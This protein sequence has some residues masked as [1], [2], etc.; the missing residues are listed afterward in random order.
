MP[1]QDLLVV[2]DDLNLAAAKLRIRSQGSAGGQKG[3]ANI[4]NRLGTEQIPRLR[5]GIGAPPDNWNAADYVLAR[6]A[7]EEKAEIDEAVATA[8]KA[9]L[10]WVR[11]G[12]AYCMN[13][14]NGPTNVGDK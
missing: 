4:I 10:D 14:Y 9:V 1:D 12:T 11:Q 8:A 7:A 13:K 2:C 3:L 6:L 5:I